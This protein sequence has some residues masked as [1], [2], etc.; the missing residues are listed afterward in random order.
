M[1]RIVRGLPRRGANAIEFGLTLPIFFAMMMAIVDYGWWF[2][3][4]AGINNAVSLGCRE[5]AMLDSAMGHDPI[6]VATTEI[7]DRAE[8]WCGSGGCTN[9]NVGYQWAVP[10]KAISCSVTMAFTPLVGLIPTPST[11]WATS[12]YRMEWQR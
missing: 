9:V 5:G 11:V 1:Q 12:R 6:A 3:A 8:P 2:G 4:Q 10:E 7:N